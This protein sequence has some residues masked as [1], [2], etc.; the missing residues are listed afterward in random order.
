MLELG[1]LTAHRHNGDLSEI[2]K[3]AYYILIS[4]TMNLN[5]QTNKQQLECRF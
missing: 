1:S 4:K 5:I 2:T 3:W